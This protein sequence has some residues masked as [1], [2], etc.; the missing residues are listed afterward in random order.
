MIEGNYGH[1]DN[2]VFKTGPVPGCIVHEVFRSIVKVRVATLQSLVAES[3]YARLGTL[4]GQV[5][6]AEVRKRKYGALLTHDCAIL[7]G[8]ESELVGSG[9]ARL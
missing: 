8:A 5:E 1:G 9:C 6:N 4:R 7:C 3:G 2:R